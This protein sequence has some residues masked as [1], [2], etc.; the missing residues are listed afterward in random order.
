VTGSGFSPQT[1]G[2]KIV[3]GPMF[4]FTTV[5][6]TGFL[7]YSTVFEDDPTRTLIFIASIM[8]EYVPWCSVQ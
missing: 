2:Q 5:H 7:M 4:Q 3:V 1:S 8:E 6:A